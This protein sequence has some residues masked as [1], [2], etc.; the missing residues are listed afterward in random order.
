MKTKAT[1][2]KQLYDFFKPLPETCVWASDLSADPN[3]GEV[4]V[5]WAG[6]PGY[7]RWFQDAQREPAF[8]YVPDAA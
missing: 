3:K 5:A 6:A 1:S 4:C 8:E 2:L 7:M